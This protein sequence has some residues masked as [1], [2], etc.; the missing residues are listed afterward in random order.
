MNATSLSESSTRPSKP[1]H[2]GL[3][4]AQILLG[5]LFGAA[6][7]AKTI[8]PIEDLTQKMVWPGAV[9]PGLVRF[10]GIS[11]F[12]GGLGLILPAATRI[13]PGLT[14]LAASGLIVIMVLA[15]IFHISRGEL[16]ALPTNVF[17]GAVAAFIAWG[18]LKKA[19]ISPRA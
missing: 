10:I 5:L 16:G 3:W 4:V 9:P 11:E 8:L 7:F 18:R 15:M 19:P 1:L 17:F 13:R 14:P 12:L 2:I 6:G